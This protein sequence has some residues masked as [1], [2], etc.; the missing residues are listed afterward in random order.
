MPALKQET[1]IGYSF[2]VETEQV[3]E[4]DPKDGQP[5]HDGLGQPKMVEQ[6]NLILIEAATGLHKVIVPLGDVQRRELI[7]QL[8]GGIHL[9]SPVELPKEQMH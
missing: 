3:Q 4:F 5:L 6:W 7:R 9:A 1:L 2:K 8:S